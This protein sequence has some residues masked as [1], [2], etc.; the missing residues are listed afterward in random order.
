MN[1]LGTIVKAKWETC[2]SVAGVRWQR[3][4]TIDYYFSM[5]R[6]APGVGTKGWMRRIAST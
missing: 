6:Q 1:E 2:S 3:T 4:W 5:L